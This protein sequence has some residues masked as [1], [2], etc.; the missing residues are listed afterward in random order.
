VLGAVM[1]IILISAFGVVAWQEQQGNPGADQH[2][3]LAGIHST[4]AGGN[5]EG[6]E[7]RFG[8]IQ[9]AL[10][11][12]ATTGTSTGSVDASMDSMTPIGGL[13]PLVLIKLGEI[14]P[15]DVGSG[16]Y[17]MGRLR[18]RGGVHRGP[19]G[20][21]NARYSARRSRRAMSNTRRSRYSSSPPR[22][23]ASQL[24]RS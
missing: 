9:S 3:R 14:T 2:R 18:N 6:K 11:N 23:W 5:M 19:D 7:A 21:K 20:W 8:P 1:G 10:Y 24:R 16:L 15:G 13:V 4:L 17:G 12:T 22:S